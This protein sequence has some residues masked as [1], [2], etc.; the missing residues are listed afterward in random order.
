MSRAE[1]DNGV[2]CHHNSLSVM[3]LVKQGPFQGK[4]D[5][6]LTQAFSLL[7]SIPQRVER[8]RVWLLEG[9]IWGWHVDKKLKAHQDIWR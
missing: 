2:M 9:C 8:E 6:D 1:G 5:Q 3:Q 7:R 4:R